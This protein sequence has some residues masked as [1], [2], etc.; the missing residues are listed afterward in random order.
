V[1]Q[2][3]EEA[4]KDSSAQQLIADGLFGAFHATRSSAANHRAFRPGTFL[5]GAG[6]FMS[7]SDTAIISI[8]GAAATRR[9]RICRSIR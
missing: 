2:P 1:F 8:H 6:P 7:A 3:A 5:F 4:G 9:G